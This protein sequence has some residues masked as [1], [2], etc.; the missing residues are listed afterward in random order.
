MQDVSHLP[1]PLLAES[2]HANGLVVIS[3]VVSAVS[4]TWYQRYLGLGV[5]DISELLWYQR[6]LGLG[7]SDILDLVSEVSRTTHEEL[8]KEVKMVKYEHGK[9]LCYDKVIVAKRRLVLNTL[10]VSEPLRRHR[11]IF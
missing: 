11:A 5:S 8:D 1:E 2:R 4:W 3:A 10:E 6:Y 7:I 9:Y